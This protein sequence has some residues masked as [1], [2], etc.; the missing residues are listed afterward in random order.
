MNK[1]TIERQIVKLRD[2]KL[3]TFVGKAE[4]AIGYIQLQGFTQDAGNEVRASI[5][6][7]QKV[8]EKESSTKKVRSSEERKTDEKVM[9]DRS[10]SVNTANTPLRDL[11]RYNQLEGLVLDLRGNPGGLLTSAV[12]VASLLVP[13][14]SDIVSARGR[15]FPSVIYR[16]RASP[17]LS[18]D[19]K[20]VV[21]VNGGTASAA[22]IVSGAVQDL[23]VGV[24]VGA[25][26]TYGKGLVQNVEELPFDTALKFTVA[27]YFT[28][29]GRC[30][31]STNYEEG[32]KASKNFKAT[33]VKAADRK[34]FKT[35]AGRSIKDGG[36]ETHERARAHT[37][38]ETADRRPP[39]TVS[40]RYRGRPQD[41]PSQGLGAR[42]RGPPLRRPGR[43]RCPVV[44]QERDQG[45]VQGHGRYVQAVPGHARKEGGE[46]RHSRAD[47]PL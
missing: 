17:L 2:V 10:N 45:G 47:K 11:L 27:K 22:E 4:D 13:K 29:S 39:N 33:S 23:D 38:T 42:G 15:G 44:L 16:S 18:P 19:T 5:T 14:N 6:A 3:T 30:I 12:D 24:I 20:L 26:R 46:W 8:A 35:R 41:P 40:R 31:Q 28:P 43:V 1:V 36:G 32:D 37:H 34:D 25:D 9:L 7:L 21:L